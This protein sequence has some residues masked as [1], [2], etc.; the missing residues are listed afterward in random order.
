MSL[1]ISSL[2]FTFSLFFAMVPFTHAKENPIDDL[3]YNPG[4]KFEPYS[5]GVIDNKSVYMG[6]YY[7][8]DTEG[9]GGFSGA[10]GIKI[11]PKK[12]VLYR[13]YKAEIC[14]MLGGARYLCVNYFG[15]AERGKNGSDYNANNVLAAFSDISTVRIFK[16][17]QPGDL[18]LWY[19]RGNHPLAV[20]A[21]SAEHQEDFFENPSGVW[22]PPGY[23]VRMC[24][25]EVPKPGE[26][27]D[28]TGDQSQLKPPIRY[29]RFGQGKPR[30]ILISKPR[31]KPNGGGTN[32]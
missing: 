4:K 21:L 17:R 9:E 29:I 10:F 24:R 14:G 3:W 27:M 25:S 1:L 15:F 32:K 26:C 13:G 8:E 12:F 16:W 22:I 7:F 18:T 11:D 31:G 2:I 23:W 30:P 19:G 20:D 28:Y 6:D 5:A